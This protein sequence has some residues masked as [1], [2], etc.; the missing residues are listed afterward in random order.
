MT[1]FYSE[2]GERVFTNVRNCVLYAIRIAIQRELTMEEMWE[3][4]GILEKICRR[5][6]AK[7][8][9][10]LLK[11]LREGTFGNGQS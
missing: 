9:N 5:E 1:T 8:E 10:K 11:Y 6:P 3:L 2:S 4:N 7:F